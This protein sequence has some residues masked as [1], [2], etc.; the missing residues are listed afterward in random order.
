MRL[1]TSICVAKW[2]CE[3]RIADMKPI[4]RFFVDPKH[5]FFL[6]G[7]R[8]TGKSTWIGMKYPDALSINLLFDEPFLQYSAHPDLLRNVVHANPDKQIV[9]IDEVQKVPALLGIVHALIEEKKGKQF[10]LT[11]SS[12]RKLKRTG[13]DLLAGRAFPRTLHPFMAAELKD[14]FNFERALNI[15]MLPIVIDSTSPKDVLKGYIKLYIREEVHAE[16]LVRNIAGFTRFLETMSFSHASQIN[17]SNISRECHVERT[18]VEEYIQI[19]E[20]LLLSC[21]LYVFT[22]RAQRELSS[23]P[24]FYLFDAGVF[25]ALR[26]T[27]PLDCRE[28]IEGPALEGLVFQHLRAWNAYS[29]DDHQIYFWRTRSGVEVDFIVYGPTAFYAIEVKNSRHLSSKDVKSLKIFQEEYPEC[30]TL[31]LYRGSERILLND[32]LCLPCDT[33]LIKLNPNST[34]HDACT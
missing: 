30:K 34:I 7:P 10:I 18:M 28:E 20:D 3:P 16:G 4:E 32:V 24:K 22:R 15:G 26:I 31:L 6:F 17:V 13:V 1:I 19:L 8:G 14:K 25:R 27:A 12:T 5:S 23:H 11:G 21:R 33:F 29:G 2:G 9:V